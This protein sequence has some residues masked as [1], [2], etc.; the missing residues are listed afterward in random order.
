MTTTTI[1]MTKNRKD[2]LEEITITVFR[3]FFV[4]GQMCR[5]RLKI[6]NEQM[7]ECRPLFYRHGSGISAA[8]IVGELPLSVHVPRWTVP[9]MR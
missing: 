5:R 8:S 1:M 3:F 2:V 4:F 9:W 7:N 6:V